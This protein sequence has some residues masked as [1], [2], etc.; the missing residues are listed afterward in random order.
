MA[1]PMRFWRELIRIELVRDEFAVFYIAAFSPN[2]C[3]LFKERFSQAEWEKLKPGR[4]FA[5][6]N[7]D[8]KCWRDIVIKDIEW[9][10]YTPIAFIGEGHSSEDSVI[11]GL[12]KEIE[13]LKTAILEHYKKSVG[14]QMCWENDEE[15]WKVVDPTLKYP[16]STT[17]SAEEMLNQCKVYIDSRMNNIPYV[18]PAVKEHATT[19]EGKKID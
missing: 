11:H 10:T 6:V 16:H 7:S 9:E 2:S 17:P 19:V 8:A 1:D 18:E 5:Q 14:H 15:L 4:Y 3:T 12:A 13:T